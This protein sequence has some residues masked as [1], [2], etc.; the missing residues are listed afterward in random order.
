MTLDEVQIN[1]SVIIKEVN[2]QGML[3]QKLFDM[4]FIEGNKIK[5]LRRSPLNDPI[6]VEILSYHLSLRVQEAQSI[7]VSYE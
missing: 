6:E 2:A 4:G 3:L 1:K 7:K 5:I